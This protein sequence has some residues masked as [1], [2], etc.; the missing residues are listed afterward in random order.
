MNNKEFDVTKAFTEEQIN[1][2]KKCVPTLFSWNAEADPNPE[3][4]DY[5]T[6][7]VSGRFTYDN[8]VKISRELGEG[9]ASALPCHQSDVIQV[10]LEYV[11]LLTG[12]AITRRD[13]LIAFCAFK[14]A[15]SITKMEGDFQRSKRDDSLMALA[16]ILKM[17]DN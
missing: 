11:R 10:C 7:T 2:I 13:A 8:S 17:K 12:G 5:F 15:E 3:T 16:A 6:G 9:I 14:A 1:E 4:N